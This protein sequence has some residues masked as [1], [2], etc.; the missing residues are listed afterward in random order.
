MVCHTA[1]L[2][3]DLLATGLPQAPSWVPQPVSVG[4]RRGAPYP[5]GSRRQAR[6][7]Y[8]S[9]QRLLLAVKKS[10]N[11]IW[12]LYCFGDVSTF[13]Q[14]ELFPRSQQHRQRAGQTQTDNEEPRASMGLVRGVA[15]SVCSVMLLHGQASAP[16]AAFSVPA[17]VFRSHNVKG[18]TSAS[19]SRAQQALSS[20]SEPLGDGR[21]RRRRYVRLHLSSTSVYSS[22]E[23]RHPGLSR[24]VNK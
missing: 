17:V 20:A 18:R 7:L 2:A 1:A 9:G 24:S 10:L 22:S 4:F 12:K 11:D 13:P 5:H 8:R 23:A 16:V 15:L 19:S 3:L 14:S 21:K 6:L